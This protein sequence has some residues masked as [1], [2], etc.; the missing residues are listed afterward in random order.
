MITTTTHL[1][2]E[3][4]LLKSKF[5]F[6]CMLI[7]FAILGFQVKVKSQSNA[8][9]FSSPND[10]VTLPYSAAMDFSITSKFTIEAWFRTTN[11]LAVLYSNHVDVSPYTGHEVAIVNSKLVFDLTNNYLTNAIRI[12]TVN[13]YNDGNWHH[14]ACVYKGIPTASNVD[15]YVDGALQTQSVSINNLSGSSNTGNAPHLG[16]RNNTAYFLTGTLDELRVWG[17]ALCAAEITA[18]KNCELVGN[19]PNLLAYY[20]FNQGVAGGSN[21]TVTTL[22]D[23]SGHNITGTLTTFALTGA[24]SNWIASTASV[25]G[26]CSYAGP[27]TVSGNTLMCIGYSNVLTGNGAT[28]YTWSTSSNS[29]SISVSPTV[30]T[31][32]SVVGTNTANGCYGTSSFTQSVSLC[33]G[34]K[35][36]N[37]LNNELLVFPNPGNGLFIING[38][39]YG[40]V[41]D[42]YNVVGEVIYTTQADSDKVQLDLLEQKNG[43]YFIKCSVNGQTYSHKIIKE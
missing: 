16:C 19:E 36:V 5:Y 40:V 25:S 14:F 18:R 12:E 7:C 38:L 43:I 41:I 26:S 29:S 22:P 23:I 9:N 24:T 2:V 21:P 10:N 27:I 28:S 6:V 1:N 11:S 42:V 37:N 17:K 20:N 35:N 31:T 4:A 8:L 34:I 15:I 32:Y 13:S 39:E 33:T 30:T 3:Q